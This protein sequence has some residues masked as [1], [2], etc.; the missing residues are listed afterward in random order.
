MKKG[1][2]A[3]EHAIIW[4]DKAPVMFKGEDKKGMT[5]APIRVAP[6]S[7]RHKLDEA[8]RLNYAKLYTVEYNVK[9]WFVGRIHQDSEYQLTADYNVEHPPMPVRG[10]PMG[11]TAAYT[12]IAYTSTYATAYATGSMGPPSSADAY[13]AQPNFSSYQTATTQ[14]YAG[15]ASYNPMPASTP[16]EEEDSGATQGAG[17]EAAQPEYERHDDLYD[18][19]EDDVVPRRRD[20]PEITRKRH[21]DDDKKG[22]RRPGS[23]G[24]RSGHRR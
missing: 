2:H 18:A 10:Y 24:G 8:S 20:D 23:G 5:K 14:G 4:T 15:A 17:D 21:D 11:A 6:F 9:V 16:N 19:E 7:S 13:Q 1:V 12:S 22:K 3:N